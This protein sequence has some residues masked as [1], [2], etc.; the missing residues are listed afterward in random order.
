MSGKGRVSVVE[1][2]LGPAKAHRP[3]GLRDRSELAKRFEILT[4]PPSWRGSN[5]SI[6]VRARVRGPDFQTPANTQVQLDASTQCAESRPRDA[7]AGER[8]RQAS[9]RYTENHR[10]SEGCRRNASD[11]AAIVTKKNLERKN[12]QWPIVAVEFAFDS[13]LLAQGIL[14]REWLVLR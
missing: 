2:G 5:V 11:D 14:S 7:C 1:A 3:S 8:Q 6:G 9:H 12:C 10:R 4:T 13:R